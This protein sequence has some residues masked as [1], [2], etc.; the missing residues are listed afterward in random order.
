MS[1]VTGAL[2]AHKTVEVK[3][4]C[5]SRYLDDVKVKVKVKGKVFPLQAR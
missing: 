4:E 2:S 3:G 5:K 1:K